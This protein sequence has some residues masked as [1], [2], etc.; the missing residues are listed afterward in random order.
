MEVIR[1]FELPAATTYIY[2]FSLGENLFYAVGDR[3]QHR[4][5]NQAWH[6]VGHLYIMA[7][8]STRP[9]AALYPQ[10]E[11]IVLCLLVKCRGKSFL[12]VVDKKNTLN[13]WLAHYS[14]K[15]EKFAEPIVPPHF[16][17]HHSFPMEEMN[18]VIWGDVFQ[19]EITIL[20][21]QQEVLRCIFRYSHG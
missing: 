7:N 14:T 8:E 1:D 19:E 13:I 12:L 18:E 16:F 21:T 9:I 3:A 20:V 11:P 10:R 15:P 4:A 5:R 6:Q 2:P 17:L